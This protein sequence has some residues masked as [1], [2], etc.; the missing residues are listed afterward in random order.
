[1]T[2][3]MPPTPSQLQELWLGPSHISGS[4]FA[5]RE[6][7]EAAWREHS[8]EVMM[9][10]Q[11]GHRPA[12]WWEFDAPKG[13]KFDDEHECSILWRANILGAEER[14]DVEEGWKAAFA[15]A[16]ARGYDAKRRREH[17]ALADVPRELLRAWLAERKR[18]GKTIRRLAADTNELSEGRS[19]AAK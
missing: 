1:M 9:M 12:A 8:A 17:Y 14:R 6:E 16:F 19:P 11:P 13:L 5:S 4:K 7:L 18:N 2:V 3:R 15:L 10:T